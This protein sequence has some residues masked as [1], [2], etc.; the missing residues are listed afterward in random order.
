M[1]KIENN[2][3][4]IK[5]ISKKEKVLNEI[6]F[7]TKGNKLDGCDII[8]SELI[9]TDSMVYYVSCGYNNINDTL[10]K[11]KTLDVRTEIN[12]LR[13]RQMKLKKKCTFIFKT[14]GTKTYVCFNLDAKMEQFIKQYNVLRKK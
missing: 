5:L 12:L 4:V 13:I 7:V 10:E 11:V 14:S 8:K 1:K 3:L 2:D 9:M 6:S